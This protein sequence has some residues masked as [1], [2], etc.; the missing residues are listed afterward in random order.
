MTYSKTAIATADV[1]GLKVYDN[2]FT[3]SGS[4]GYEAIYINPHT[5]TGTINI[6]NNQ[7]SGAA[8]IGITVE[9]GNAIVSNNIVTTNVNQEAAPYGTYG[10]RFFDSSYVATFDDIII[11]I[12]FTFE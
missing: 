2:S 8:N 6:S 11:L 7:I 12:K 10:I 1:S 3:G 9:S 5:G 4:V